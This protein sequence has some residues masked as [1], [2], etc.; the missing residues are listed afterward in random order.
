[1]TSIVDGIAELIAAEG[2]GD[3]STTEVLDPDLV[4]I[5]VGV[6]P[7]TAGPAVTL[8]VY[9]GPE[10]DSRNGWENPRLQV[11]VRHA[12]VLAALALDRQVYDALQTAGGQ[13]LPGDGTW[14]LQDCYA[15]QS[16][17]QQLGVDGNGRVEYVRNWQLSTEP[18]T[19]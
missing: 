5:T 15:L 11:R 4:P 1:M 10:P 18:A 9:P 7:P 13:V 2:W 16:E 12:D 19:P 6:S 14:F 3:Y 17:P 8:T